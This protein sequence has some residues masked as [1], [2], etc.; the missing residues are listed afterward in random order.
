[1][2]NQ[3]YQKKWLRKWYEEE[4]NNGI[5]GECEQVRRFITKRDIN[6]EMS[7]NETIRKWIMILKIIKKKAEKIKP[8][9]ISWFSTW[10]NV[11]NYRNIFCNNSHAQGM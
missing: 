7:I 1:M 4:K 8:N 6:V 9:N 3:N 5:N 11:H 2:H 10:N